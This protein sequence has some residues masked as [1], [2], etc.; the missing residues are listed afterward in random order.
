M[1]MAIF[2]LTCGS[3]KEADVISK[4]LLEK[5]LIACAKTLS[6]SSNFWW[7]SKLD[8]AEEVLL[9]MESVE[10]NFEKTNKEVKKLHSYETF[11]LYSLPVNQ[12]TKDVEE[13]LKKELK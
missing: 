3:Q 2:V 7:K 4:A 13:W 5:R 9:Q 11:V 12:T 1:K 10:E 8:S 6:V